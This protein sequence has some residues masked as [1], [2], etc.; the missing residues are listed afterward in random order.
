MYVFKFRQEGGC[1][2]RVCVNDRVI[3]V[4]KIFNT[5]YDIGTKFHSLAVWVLNLKYVFSLS[6]PTYCTEVNIG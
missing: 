3:I 2:C 5:L 1:V 4:L 6:T